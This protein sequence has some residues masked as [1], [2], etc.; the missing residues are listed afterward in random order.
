MQQW[1]DRFCQKHPRLSIPGLMRY[2]VIG[3]VVVFLLDMF[4]MGGTGLAS[5]LLSFRLDSILHGQVWRL[6]TF[7]FVPYSSRNIFLFAITLYFYYF[8]GTALEREWGSNKFTIFY[9]FGVVLNILLGFLL[10][11]ASMYYV[12]MSMFFAFATLY[13]NL[14]FLLFFIIFCHP[15]QGQ[16]AG[17]D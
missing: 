6:I 12:N 17:V 11:T 14:Q 10:G 1:L 13:P 9:L 3:S 16:V 8:I 4:S 5:S 2:I 7:I 15:G